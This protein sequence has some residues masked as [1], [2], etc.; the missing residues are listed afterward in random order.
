MN[1]DIR[2]RYFGEIRFIDMALAV[3]LS[4]DGVTWDPTYDSGDGIHPNAAGAAQMKLQAIAD[5]PF[6]V[7]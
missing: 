4:H 7:E 5:C 6:L 1:N 3:S 2:A